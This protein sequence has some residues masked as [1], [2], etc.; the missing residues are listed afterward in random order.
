MFCMSRDVL[1]C[2]ALL[3]GCCSPDAAM[4]W[5]AVACRDTES[6]APGLRS[7]LFWQRCFPEPG[8]ACLP[9]CVSSLLPQSMCCSEGGLAQWIPNL[10]SVEAK[11]IPWGEQ[12]RG[13]HTCTPHGMGRF[14]IAPHLGTAELPE[15]AASACSWRHWVLTFLLPCSLKK[16]VSN[17]KAT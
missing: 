16:G 10:G 4:S 5:H 14:C 7:I 3:P 8:W 6:M 13:S 11:C 15:Q 12:P 2:S 17:M 1:Y 9:C